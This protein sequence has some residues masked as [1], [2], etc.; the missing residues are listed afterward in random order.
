MWLKF[1]NVVNVDSIKEEFHKVFKEE[2][3]MLKGLE[4]E[5]EL[6]STNGLTQIL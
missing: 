1:V 6:N 5:I 3:G 2:L 4:A